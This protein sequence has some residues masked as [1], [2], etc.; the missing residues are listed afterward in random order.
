M[1]LPWVTEDD[2]ELLILS[3]LG[4]QVCIAT[5]SVFGARAS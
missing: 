2:L 4:L 5:P 1:E 3:V